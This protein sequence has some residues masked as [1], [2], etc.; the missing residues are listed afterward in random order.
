[1]KALIVLSFAVKS[2]FATSYLQP[3]VFTSLSP[4][5]RVCHQNVNFHNDFVLNVL[6]GHNQVRFFA[7]SEPRYSTHKDVVAFVNNKNVQVFV[8]TNA[9]QRFGFTGFNQTVAF[10]VRNV[11]FQGRVVAQQIVQKVKVNGFLHGANATQVK[12]AVDACR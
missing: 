1:M 2:V 10:C 7:V 5:D 12:F 11:V 6:A 3:F 4:H 8:D 9:F